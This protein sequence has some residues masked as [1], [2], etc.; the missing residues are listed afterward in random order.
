[1]AKKS[2][3]IV[4][5]GTGRRK[6][7]IARVRLVE[8]SGKITVNGKSID[9]FFGAETIELNHGIVPVQIK[10]EGGKAGV[11]GQGGG[12]R[13]FIAG[14]QCGNIGHIMCKCQGRGCFISEDAHGNH[15]H[16]HDERK[17]QCK[18]SFHF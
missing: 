6:E 7:S 2:E 3:N 8:G 9:E 4:F 12:D 15:A 13:K 11:I 18:C 14:F 1:M 17:D 16:N 5:Q 10:L